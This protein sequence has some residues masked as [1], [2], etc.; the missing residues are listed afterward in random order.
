MSARNEVLQ[1]GCGD[2]SLFGVLH[3]PEHPLRR[4]VLIITG[5]PQYRVGSH[6]QFVLL[7][8]HLA[9]KGLATMRFDYRG[10]GDSEGEARDFDS[11]GEDIAAAVAHFFSTVPALRELVLLGL[12]DGASAAAFYAERDKRICG[13]VLLN[14][15]VRT[16]Q[17][18]AR[19]TL[20]HYYWARLREPAFWRKLACG[21]VRLGRVLG[22]LAEV[23]AS[24]RRG[25]D[26][27]D[28][29]QR[30]FR[31]LSRFRGRILIILS[32]ADLTARE[33]AALERRHAHWRALLSGA[34][35]H[36]TVL[37]QANHTFARADWRMQVAQTC[38]DWIATW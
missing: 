10:M 7:A 28:L 25:Q 11:A 20:R 32:G 16:D 1:F 3:L 13:L 36:R 27:A 21:A 31:A 34:R 14:P 35:V 26:G 19:A 24:A 38:A 8:R 30:L 17:G 23:A 6:R 29:P 37:P 4:G 12:C 18:I 5:G 9:D 15:W 2:C 33:F 22:G